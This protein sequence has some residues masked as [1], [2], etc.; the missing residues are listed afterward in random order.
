MRLAIVD[1]LALG[2]AVKEHGFAQRAIRGPG[3]ASLHWA[4]GALGVVNN[5]TKNFFAL[6]RYN[7]MISLGAV[8]S[9][10]FV[11]LGPLLGVIFAPRAAKFGFAIALLA[12][13]I[14]YLRM[15]YFTGVSPIYFFTHPLAVI[16]VMY[17]MLRS[18]FITL[19]QGG[20]IWRGTKYSL[21]ELRQK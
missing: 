3:L 8:L 6:M 10:A 7:W 4:S 1:D 14:I 16:L 18:T 21:D 13:A 12:N 11:G 2:K 19:W 5:L 17:T 9:S 20:V 15:E